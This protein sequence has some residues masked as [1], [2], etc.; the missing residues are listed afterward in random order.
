MVPLV[1]ARKFLDLYAAEL[2]FRSFGVRER[3]VA[4]FPAR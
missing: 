1:I 4:C 3:S 2:I